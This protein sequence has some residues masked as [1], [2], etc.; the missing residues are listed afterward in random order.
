MD[1]LLFSSFYK[2]LKNNEEK[3][4]SN[5]S[6]FNFFFEIINMYINCKFI[7][8]ENKLIIKNL[9]QNLIKNLN[10]SFSL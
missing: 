5:L 4:L 6:N 8:K 2:A 9:K 7:L 10:K 1:N 3:L